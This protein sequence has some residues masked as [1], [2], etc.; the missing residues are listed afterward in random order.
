MRATVPILALLV[1]GLAPVLLLR[2]PSHV[3]G[4]TPVDLGDPL[5]L[6]RVPLD[7]DQ[8]PKELER[9]RKGLLL[10]LPRAE[11]EERVR[12]AAQAQ[13]S[14]KRPPR[15][16]EARYRARLEGTALVGAGQWKVI[17]PGA[18][19][20]VLSLD[21]LN[22]AVRQP[23]FENGDA[24][25]GEF[26]GKSVGLL[27]DQS[28]PRSATLD[29]TARGDPGPDG[30]QFDLKI[31]SCAVAAL[32]LDL[33][34][35][36]RLTVSPDGCVVSGPQSADKSDRRL[37]KVGFAGRSQI[38]LIIQQAA[39]PNQ[40]APLMLAAL[41]TT[42]E[43]TPDFLLSEYQFDLQAPRQGVR[44]LVCECDP[45]LRPY[46]VSTS[47]M[48]SW[49][50]LPA[51]TAGAPN[52]LVVRL[53]E[54]VTTGLLVVRCL[55]P[56]SANKAEGRSVEWRSPWL[57]LTQTVPRG[58][59]LTLRLHPEVRLDDWQPN[60]FHLTDIAADATGGRVLTL[61][62]GGIV[63][64]Q[65][66]KTQRDF[67]SAGAADRP[68]ARVPI[69]GADY[70]AR[71]LVWWQIHS[72]Q[73]S[74]TAQITYEVLQG[75][76]FQLPV[77]VPTGWEVERVEMAP[78]TL[79][80]NWG[81]KPEGGRSLLT[82]ELQQA[83]T[84]PRPAAAAEP[85]PTSPRLSLRLRPVRSKSTPFSFERK[86]FSSPFPEI[87][88]KGARWP[89][90]A[91]AIEYDAGAYQAA[92]HS[93]QA[94]G[95][96]EE[97]EP[98]GKQ[99]P[100]FYFP[101]RGQSLKGSLELRPRPVR[102]RSR[103]VNEVVLEAGRPV[104]KARLTLE[105]EAGV[106]DYLDFL[107][108]APLGNHWSWRTE[109]GSTRVRSFEPLTAPEMALSLG[110]L[111]SRLPLQSMSV[112]GAQAWG[113]RWRLTLARPPRPHEP[114]T[115]HFVCEVPRA[116]AVCWKTPLLSLQGAG[117]V[118][119]ETR[120]RLAD[121]QGLRL[122]THGL[123][124]V[125]AES[126][127]AGSTA[128]RTYRHRQPP[129]SLTLFGPLSDTSRLPQAR[130]RSAVLT[131]QMLPDRLRCA[132][133]FW[134]ENWRRPTLPVTLPVG[135]RLLAVSRDGERVNATVS[136]E[137]GDPLTLDLP[138]P[139]DDH[140]KSLHAFEIVY[141]HDRPAGTLWDRLGAPAPV[142]PMEPLLFRRVWR[143]PE[144][145]RPLPDS[146]VTRM[147]ESAE[148]GETLPDKTEELFEWFPDRILP[149]SPT[150][151]WEARQRQMLVEAAAG[152]RKS[153]SGKTL[154]LR[155]ALERLAFGLLQDH[156]VV[157]LH[158]SALRQA[159][160]GPETPIRLNSATSDREAPPFW[161][162]LGLVYVPC[163]A[164][165]LLTTRQQWELWQ[166]EAG[167][168]RA[169][170]AFLDFAVATAAARGHDSSGRLRT[171]SDWLRSIP[172]QTS[173]GGE[174]T[175]GALEPLHEI[176]PKNPSVGWMEWESLAADPEG[177]SLLIV[178]QEAVTVAGL[179]LAAA[180]AVPF[181]IA[182]RSLG[183]WRL[184]LLALWL[185][186]GGLAVCWLP[187][188]L[189][190]LA[191]WP[192]M[193]GVVVAAG[194]YLLSALL[195]PARVNVVV[196]AAKGPGALAPAILILLSFAGL[197]GWAAP[198][199]TTIHESVTVFLVPGPP[200]APEKQTV[201]VPVD[202][203]DKLDALAHPPWGAPRGAVLLSA[204]YEG[205]I[206]DHS[207]DF[208]TVFQAYSFDDKSAT[209]T[210]PLQGVRLQDE[211]LLDGAAAYPV[212]LGPQQGGY[213]V[214]VEGRGPHTL[215]VHFRVPI[216]TDGNNRALQFTAP[217]LTQSRLAVNLPPDAADPQ[218][219]ARLG[220]QHVTATPEGTRLEADIGRVSAP[221]LV[222]WR[223]ED[224]PPT[225][226]TVQ[227]REAYLWDL[228]ADASTL[229]AV[230]RYQ[231][232]RGSAT[233]LEL[234]LP[235]SL[236]VRS[237]ETRSADKGKPAPRLKE[238]QVLQIDRQRRLRLAFQSAVAGEAMVFLELVPR[239][240][241]NSTALLPLPTPRDAQSIQGYL[242]YRLNGVQAHVKDLAHL[243]GPKIEEFSA[244]WRAAGEDE[245]R[246]LATAFAITRKPESAP[247][248]RLQLQIPKASFSGK[249]EIAWRVGARQADFLATS[250]L[251]ALGDNL[252]MVE[253]N[254][255]P[256]LVVARVNGSHVWHWSQTGSH[257]QVWFQQA[258]EVTDIQW[259]GWFPL[260]DATG[261]GE[262]KEKKPALTIPFELPC[263]R[264]LSAV[265]QTSTVRIAFP[266]GLALG[267]AHLHNLISL[268]EASAPNQ[269]HAYLAREGDYGGTFLI[270]PLEEQLEARLLTTAE[271][272][273][274]Q[275]TFVVTVD[276]R[277][278]QGEPRRLSLRLNDWE[279]DEVYLEATNANHVSEQRR[280]PSSRLWT[281]ELQPDAPN[282]YRLTLTLTCPADET[283]G[284]GVPVPRVSVGN[285][286]RSD[287]WLAVRGKEL[288]PTISPNQT[289][290]T[291]DA[292][293]GTKAAAEWQKAWP[294]EAE[295]LRRL[296]GSVWRVQDPEVPSRLAPRSG[297]AGANPIH[298]F[299]MEQ[300][301][302]QADGKNLLHQA[303]CWLHHQSNTELGVALPAGAGLVR[304][305]V[306]GV[307]ADALPAGPSR[308]WLRLPD[309]RGACLIT[310]LW[311][312]DPG[313]ESLDR[314][315]LELPR[316]EN[317]SVDETVWTLQ[318]PRG[319]DAER[320][321]AASAAAT[322]ATRAELD[323]RRAEAQMHLS[324]VLAEQPR[325]ASSA[326]QLLAAQQRFY[327]HCRFAEHD[328]ARS[329]SSA[330][331]RL[332]QLREQDKELARSHSFEK[333][334]AEAERTALSV[335]P[336]IPGDDLPEC[337]VP[338]YWQGSS[339]AA[340]PQP[341]L[342]SAQDLETRQNLA[343][344]LAL[345]CVLAMVGVLSYFPRVL[346]W[347]RR[348]WPEQMAL[349]GCLIWLGNG[350][351][352]AVYVLVRL[353]ILG[354]LLEVGLWLYRHWCRP[355]T[356]DNAPVNG[357]PSA[358]K[359]T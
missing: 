187:S 33:P 142:L 348:F 113:R 46:E 347:V 251:S 159:G 83:L 223:Q 69:R 237:A 332:Q 137:R 234:D 35:D 256:A 26:D 151:D 164:A 132:Y 76:L 92:I 222:R 264:L 286:N 101:F 355:A 110:V 148:M 186:A 102:L 15:L 9:V 215:R 189:Q 116:G 221:V 17:H 341:K 236:E 181:G 308:Y 75:H 188:A 252:F 24:L 338:L 267:H 150:S 282:P 265:S 268:P 29:W 204:T 97:E 31:P 284:G 333:T 297:L 250:H 296:G 42:Q 313:P 128:W 84:P 193:A 71:T 147:P 304:A 253:W 89:E 85:A 200:E 283:V 138:F 141:V 166:G 11:F 118:E 228:R 175:A 345:L 274:R 210:L 103:C 242:A 25:I 6:Q 280:D 135:V 119:G 303:A 161:A 184:R 154:P 10:Q 263:V 260:P 182:W 336:T 275:V 327:Q 63:Q 317:A 321:P 67:A 139:A 339:D 320:T 300:T 331:E 72:D 219:P 55:A 61:S 105:S 262:A 129:L 19:P 352:L 311:K 196:P 208:E 81:V 214:K 225:S 316:F 121:V 350:P 70:R 91:L 88:P 115:L 176:S 276:V 4:E 156:E 287:H 90:G 255:P 240:A 157:V 211:V 314:P 322:P 344:S 328:L 163:R 12:Q 244:F 158:A 220:E 79:L 56:L 230:F 205:K 16:I 226:P 249:Q 330:S 153:Q 60:G 140:E 290:V 28:G 351:P 49:E 257:L 133:H 261:K 117:A 131:S 74:V 216:Q 126:N 48:E 356:I 233:T 197:A 248:L 80:R 227:V 295:R 201:L 44:E 162:S 281:V 301:I 22:L 278:P 343:L 1:C 23:R 337:G 18:S 315:L 104:M 231:I 78:S 125:L 346:L 114:I 64:D 165:P 180:L 152:L 245:P 243:A 294:A 207:A 190:G 108:S 259:S 324:A 199:T 329:P 146:Q 273:D 291:V 177:S 36:R 285:A 34:A 302:A 8:L 170:G 58:E 43:L 62:G 51:K 14:V 293:P 57:R 171:V 123:E 277:A 239:Q 192:W 145:M 357:Q 87:V 306:D 269:E 94:A 82:V 41:K 45:L 202:L 195:T 325:D 359:P 323:L 172:D 136:E 340:A 232:A 224:G 168:P 298:V 209:L 326:A 53:H 194:W 353:A 258:V 3:H 20:A 143:L 173:G 169:V 107:V 198:P 111:G 2:A 299:V 39:G 47:G 358:A 178:R 149:L 309:E 38:H 354:R 218:A 27:L 109:A 98:W 292:S 241:F 86:T 37:W 40:S 7:A 93:P 52:T 155:E 185:T 307:E 254:V 319:Y 335:P 21:P 54:P 312:Y 122:E 120:L 5:P 99:L 167:R 106:P 96:P 203:L 77:Q 247:L 318:V 127:S 30:L 183:R 50:L 174:R 59:T 73:S 13:E 130:F 95:T 66:E 288:A 206:A 134:I 229:R 342:N 191:W 272:R 65:S 32:E 217:R 160:I 270:R 279:G 212:A 334:R 246:R 349:I 289:P 235:D 310:L 213:S 271:L 68:S 305:T 124:E 100:D 238:W 179:V 266:P 112:L 144:G